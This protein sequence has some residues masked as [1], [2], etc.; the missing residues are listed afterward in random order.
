M[1]AERLDFDAL[2]ESVADGAAVDWASVDSR[3]TTPAARRRVRNL[4]LVARVA[5][6]HRTLIPA[7]SSEESD[8][9]DT[10]AADPQSPVDVERWGQL[11]VLRRIAGGAF[12]DVYLARDPQL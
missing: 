7:E 10:R 5:E 4:R 9:A 11:H 12:G 2:L 6:L 1:K 3:A 8:V